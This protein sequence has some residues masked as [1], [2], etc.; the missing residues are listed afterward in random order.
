[1]EEIIVLAQPFNEIPGNQTINLMSMDYAY[2]GQ[3]FVR[4]EQS[5]QQTI[6]SGNVKRILKVD[7]PYVKTV[8]NVEG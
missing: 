6:I 8:I 7:W 4:G 2:M 1:M 5:Q 3:P